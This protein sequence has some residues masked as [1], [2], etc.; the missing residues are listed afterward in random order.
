MDGMEA[1][2]GSAT[3]RGRRRPG[4]G[5]FTRA[6][7]LMGLAALGVFYWGAVGTLVG[8][9]LDRASSGSPGRCGLNVSPIRQPEFMQI[10][11]PERPWMGTAGPAWAPHP[12]PRILG[13][14]YGRPEGLLVDVPGR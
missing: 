14:A 1:D 9:R 12:R 4:F 8:Y 10:A 7:G 6:Q 13:L 5:R 11:P 3:G 2:S